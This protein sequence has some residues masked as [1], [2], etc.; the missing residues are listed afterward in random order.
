MDLTISNNFLKQR[1]ALEWHKINFYL[2]KLSPTST[3]SFANQLKS[4]FLENALFRRLFYGKVISYLSPSMKFIYIESL[5]RK[6]KAEKRIIF[7]GHI[8]NSILHWNKDAS[9]DCDLSVTERRFFVLKMVL[10]VSFG[11]FLDA[12]FESEI[13]KIFPVLAKISWQVYLILKKV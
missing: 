8:K 10:I 6:E 13:W 5:V 12:S 9:A 2:K 11:I 7:Y 1:Q 3:L 4:N